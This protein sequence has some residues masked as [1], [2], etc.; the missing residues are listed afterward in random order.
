[1]AIAAVQADVDQNEADA[2]AAIEAVQADVDQNEADADV[3]IAAVQADV[4]QN[5]ADADA[6]NAAVQNELDATQTGAGL[7]PDG[8][9]SAIYGTYY[10]KD[11]NSLAEATEILDARVRVNQRNIYKNAE[12]SE[13]ALEDLQVKISDSL[14]NLF[15]DQTIAGNKMFS[16]D[17]SV[18]GLTLGKGSGN[19][20]SNVALGAYTLNSNTV[21]T[22]NL[23]IG[24]N[25]L[26]ANTNGSNNSAIGSQALLSNISGGANVAVGRNSLKRNTNGSENVGVG[27]GSLSQNTSGSFNS[28]LGL[29]ALRDNTTGSHNLALGKSA[30]NRN[31]TGDNNVAIGN[32]SLWGNETGTNNIA[33]GVSANTSSDGLDNA[34]VI[35]ND[36]IVNAS[37]TI[38]LGNTDITDVITSGTLTA[39]GFKTPTGTAAEYLMADGTVSTLLTGS[40]NIY[41]TLN[42]S[43]LVANV[44]YPRDV[45]LPSSLGIGVDMNPGYEFGFNTMVLSENNL[46]ILFNDTSNS[47]AFPN[48]DWQ[49]VANDSNNGG[50]NYFSILNVTDSIVGIKVR[51]N[52]DLVIP[53]DGARLGVGTANPE[54][55]LDV[56]GDAIINSTIRIVGGSPGPGKVL[57]ATNI[58]G[59]AVWE[60]PVPTAANP[61]SSMVYQLNTYYPELGGYVIEVNND[62]THGLVVAAQ[63][64]GTSNWFEANDLMSDALNHNADGAQFKDWRLPT[65]RECNLVYTVF[66][67]IG[68]NTGATLLWSST[69]SGTDTAWGWNYDSGSQTQI[70]KNT[71]V[72]V[73]SVRAF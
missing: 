36:A 33:V 24:D 11:A 35:G 15:S 28:A 22:E 64:Q 44:S 71:V 55:T 1:M 37:N 7:N 39:P 60:T 54:A 18:N 16:S 45:I 32:Y 13:E 38:Q 73:R 51:D 53:S 31:R 50:E 19:I 5:E 68:L 12:K 34:I 2:D 29:Q 23:A 14:V 70:N 21:G 42:S 9:Y 63:E 26:N 10:I 8:T 61:F 4:D 69:Q 67:A 56:Q 25:S 66:D 58:S 27:N 46:R 49:L 20:L 40:D 47:A 62:G 41:W 30:L 52:G 3:A 59:D 65:R 43:D 57:T 48:K 72:G 6:A 17:L